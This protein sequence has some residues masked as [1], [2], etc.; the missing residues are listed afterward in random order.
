MPCTQQV[1]K[2]TPTGGGGDNV[3][4]MT[5]VEMVVMTA[6]TMA[7]LTIMVMGASKAQVRVLSDRQRC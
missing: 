2:L 5:V 4:V 7:M 3:V 6:V 1:L